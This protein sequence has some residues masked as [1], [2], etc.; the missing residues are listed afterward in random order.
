MVG[1]FLI[2]LG[3][4]GIKPCVS[5]FGGDQFEAEHVRFLLFPKICSVCL[6]CEDVYVIR[7]CCA[8]TGASLLGKDVGRC[9]VGWFAQNLDAS[10]MGSGSRTGLVLGRTGR[11]CLKSSK[12]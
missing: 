6:I 8:R 4:G 9:E 10:G 1:L 7:S 12:W 2:A 5:A 3:T 11:N